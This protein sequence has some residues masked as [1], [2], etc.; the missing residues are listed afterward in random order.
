M[1]K[2]DIQKLSIYSGSSI[3]DA[4]QAI[5]LGE[6]GISLV[7]DK[8]TQAFIRVL[9]DGDIRRALL[10]GLGLQSSIDSAPGYGR[11]TANINL[12]PEGINDLFSDQV[13]VL[14]V[15]DD[16]HQVVDLYFRDKRS[17][18]AVAKPFFDDDEIELVNECMVT[19][20][21]SSGGR[22]V[23]LFEE[24]V[25][26]HSGTNYAVSCSSGTAALHL[27]LLAH[28]IGEGDEVIVPTLTFIAPITEDFF[29][30]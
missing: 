26:V 5:S 10:D 25:A 21:V 12:A 23:N 8:E 14:P 6:I 17:H 2:I 3:R 9:T 7:L 22:F 29:L 19:G 13:R 28:G 11:G 20:W 18:L 4:M 15:V 16:D 30:L 24:M 1:N 27:L